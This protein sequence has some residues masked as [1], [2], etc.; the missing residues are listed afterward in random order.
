MIREKLLDSVRI[1]YDFGV[2][3]TN[4]RIEPRDTII[5]WCGYSK[6]PKPHENTIYAAYRS[7]LHNRKDDQKE[8]RLFMVTDEKIA[9]L[10]DLYG[11]IYR[12]LFPYKTPKKITYEEYCEMV[13]GGVPEGVVHNNPTFRKLDDIR[14]ELTELE[15]K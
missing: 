12:V 6:L 1:A 10:T 2:Q 3:Q 13:Y 8:Y 15:E 7:G 11:Q 9:I 4:K 5:S 14:R